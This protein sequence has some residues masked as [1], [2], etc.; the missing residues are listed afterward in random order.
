[1]PPPDEDGQFGAIL[2][3]FGRS[4]TLRVLPPRALPLGTGTQ[5]PV[6]LP[7]R[8]ELTNLPS[9]GMQG[10]IAHLGSPGSCISWS[11]AYGLGS[12]T[13]ARQPDGA[14][15]WDPREPQNQASSAFLYALIHAR[16]GQQCPT[17]SSEG[18]LTQLVLDGAPSM[19][20]V[21]YAPDCC[22][23][24]GIDVEQ[25]FPMETR[26]RIGSFGG[27]PLPAQD[28]NADPVRTL[29]LLKEFLA[30]GHAVAFAGPVF[31]GFS[32]PVLDDGVFYPTSW[33][34]STPAKP[35]G[36]GMLLVGYDD[37]IGDARK[38]RG[39][40][41]VQN[42][43]GTNWPPASSNSPAPPGRFYLSYAAFLGSQLTA[44]VAYPLDERPTGAAPLH[45]S[46]PGAPTAHVTAGHQWV[47][48]APAGGTRPA[49][50]IVVHRFSDPVTLESV[51]IAEPPPSSARATQTNG[52]AFRN[53]YTYV[54][55]DDGYSF[56]PG[57]Y[58]VTIVAQTSVGRVTYTGTVQ[59]PDPGGFGPSLP[60]AAMPY[61]LVGS[62]GTV[63]D[64]ER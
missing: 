7:R 10:T 44:Q 35:C 18:Y 62:T 49:T 58:A 28:P 63:I 55:R 22:Y 42:S 46:S 43:F 2:S 64:V 6:T 12:Y 23:I 56:L 50:L 40:F 45:A 9:V 14:I 21:P 59:M 39:A 13:A 38:G 19:A 60:L 37:D 34:E 17:G 47:G 27:I 36:H 24:N 61:E 53:G 52:Y 54:V 5:S 57:A 25:T 8:V 4:S 26:F 1:V 16:E 29:A 41:L 51:T 48:D 20:D 31:T 33:C 30:A 11:F 32:A 3:E 15:R